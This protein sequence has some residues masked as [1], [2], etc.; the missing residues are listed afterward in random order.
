M[1]RLILA[2][3]DGLLDNVLRDVLTRIDGYSHCVTEFAR[4]TGTLL[5]AHFFTRI[6]PE[7]L[8]GGRTEAGVPVRVQMLGSDPV[9]MADNAAVLA[10]LSPP[11]IDLNFGCPSPTVNSHRGGAALLDEPELLYAI[12]AAMRQRIPRS[13]PFTA[14]MRLGFSDCGRARECAQ[15]LEAGG[16]EELVVH[17]RTRQQLY[18]P[19]AHWGEILPLIEAV[20]IPIV[21]NGEVWTVE[22]WQRCRDESGCTDV[23]LARGA[24]SDPFLARRICAFARGEQSPTRA[25]EWVEL[26]PLLARFWLAVSAKLEPQHRPGRL[27]QWLILLDRSFPQARL[28]CA[29][30]RPLREADEVEAVLSRHLGGAPAQILESTSTD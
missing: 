4:V 2:P 8:C 26:L 9:L 24:V 17:A 20:K 28:L 29:E 21:A 11:G 5:P 19:P 1:P 27:K 15:A 25:Q 16:I 6:S 7:L 13:I 23:M 18:R 3:M 12:A 10:R 30:V 14:K 22:D